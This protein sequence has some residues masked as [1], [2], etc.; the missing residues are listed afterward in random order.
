MLGTAIK[1]GV[2]RMIGAGDTVY[3]PPGVPHGIKQSQSITY[4]NIRFEAREAKE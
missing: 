1:S 4:L 3:I 2:T